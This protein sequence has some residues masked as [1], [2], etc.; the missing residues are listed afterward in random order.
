MATYKV[1]NVPFL[2]QPNDAVC[3]YT[4]AQ[5]LY[6]W[7]KKNGSGKM[8][9]PAVGEKSKPA[10]DAPRTWP[11]ASNL[12]LAKDLKMLAKDTEYVSLDYDCLWYVLNT[13]GPIWTS[14]YK[15]WG[16]SKYGHVV[17]IVGTRTDGVFI[18]D[19]MPVNGG[20]RTWLTWKQIKS[21]VTA[22]DEASYH[23]LLAT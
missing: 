20:T 15:N 19:P 16:G 11:A 12:A 13:A 8:K 21:A 2:A 3:W 23:Y 10:F 14:V 22:Q 5:M 9:D 17:V 6:Q 18:H 7:S 1:P 4:C